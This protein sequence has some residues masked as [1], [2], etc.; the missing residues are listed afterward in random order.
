MLKWFRSILQWLLLDFPSVQRSDNRLS[1]W[2]I[3]VFVLCLQPGKKCFLGHVLYCHD[4]SVDIFR[5]RGKCHLSPD[6]WR[7]WVS[8]ARMLTASIA[9]GHC[10][11]YQT[12]LLVLFTNSCKHVLSIINFTLVVT[13]AA[14]IHTVTVTFKRC[15][16]EG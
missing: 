9:D 12:G 16:N 10:V 5:S 8:R 4:G 15:I 2:L 13:S 14:F 3:D 6:I 11:S 1:Q 7:C